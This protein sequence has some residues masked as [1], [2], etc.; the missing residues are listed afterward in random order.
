[1]TKL[2]AEGRTLWARGI[3]SPGARALI[4]TQVAPPTLAVDPRAHGAVLAGRFRGQLD[5]GEGP[6]TANEWLGF[7]A[8]FSP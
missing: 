4:G 8:R 7:V 2:S 3:V 6:L 5:F 1:M